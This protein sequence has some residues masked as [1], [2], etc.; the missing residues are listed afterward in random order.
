MNNYKSEIEKQ[1]PCF[2]HDEVKRILSD[3]SITLSE[4]AQAVHKYAFD[5]ACLCSDGRV[6]YP[7][8]AK[9]IESLLLKWFMA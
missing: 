9:Y 4:K 7:A 6:N 3:N 5:Y 8:S 1:I 2:T